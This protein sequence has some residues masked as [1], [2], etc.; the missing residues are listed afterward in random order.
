MYLYLIRHGESV[1]NVQDIFSGRTIETD[2]PL[3][4]KGQSQA[5]KTARRLR[6]LDRALTIYYS[7]ARRAT[8][9]AQCLARYTGAKMIADERI[10]GLDVGKLAGLTKEEAA[11]KFP[12]WYSNLAIRPDQYSLE[13]C[14]PGGETNRDLFRRISEFWEKALQEQVDS[15]VQIVVVAHDDVVEILCH[16]IMGLSYAGFRQF[17]RVDNCSVTG[18]EFDHGVPKMNYLN[19]ISHL[20]RRLY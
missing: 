7:T 18:I 12:E 2:N 4:K 15:P 11:V 17:G 9:T 8:A 13:Y 5:R 10:R 6:R 1:C 16:L 14:L 19:D 3:T 20:R